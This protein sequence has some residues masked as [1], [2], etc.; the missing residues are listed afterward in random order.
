[1]ESG[2]TAFIL[3]YRTPKE[4]CHIYETTSRCL[5]FAGQVFQSFKHRAISFVYFCLAEGSGQIRFCQ[6]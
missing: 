6:T 3:G 5:S 1:M 4:N 2:S